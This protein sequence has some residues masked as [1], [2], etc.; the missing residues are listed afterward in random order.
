ML[1]ML[2]VLQLIE[3]A[4]DS[5]LLGAGQLHGVGQYL[6]EGLFSVEPPCVVLPGIF[7]EHVTFPEA[8]R[9]RGPGHPQQGLVHGLIAGGGP[10]DVALVQCQ[11]RSDKKRCS[12]V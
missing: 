2:L 10:L 6:I 3:I 8:V 12:A 4:P 9:P 1:K 7:Q 11:S 5:I